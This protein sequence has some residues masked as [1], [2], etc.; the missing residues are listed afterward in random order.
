MEKI[1][2]LFM[3]S[4]SILE[5]R[6][7]HALERTI[8]AADVFPAFPVFTKKVMIPTVATIISIIAATITPPFIRQFLLLS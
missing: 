1:M 8:S 4:R 5:N 6:F 2:S 7:D 3:S